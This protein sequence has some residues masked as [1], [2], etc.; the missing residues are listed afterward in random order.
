MF[1]LLHGPDEFASA[2]FV[3]ALKE[4][5]G[6]PALASLNT[7]LFDGRAVTLSDLRG[8]CDALPFL[9]PI[10]LVIVE[11]WLT[12]LL[13]KG[14]ADEGEAASSSSAKETLAALGDY[15]PGL[16]GTTALVFVEKREI[17]ARHPLLKAAAN[18]DWGL[19]KFFDLPKGEALVKWILARAKKEGGAV[20]REAAQA[21][22][23]AETDPR[24]L[25]SEIVKLLTY[26]DFA[27]AVDVADVE[28]LTPAGGEAKI[29]DLVDAIGQR[30]GPPALR[31]LH[32]LLEREEPLYVLGMVVRHFRHMLLAAEML[33]ARLGE[34]EIVRALGLHPFPAGKICA[35]ARN[36]SLPALERLYRRLLDYDADIKTGQMDPAAALDTLVASLTA[37]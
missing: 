3:E 30:R 6:D 29:F 1:Y 21:L 14:E 31:E 8:A 26:A 22:A 35:Q 20:T 36:F 16:P 2:E 12:R 7:T 28:A 18:G 25:E 17:P 34:A 5:M 27:R 13:G 9:S 19:V 11:G 15:L 24:A 10:R 37:A 4:K 23:S 32:K 33:E